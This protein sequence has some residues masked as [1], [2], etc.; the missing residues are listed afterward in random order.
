VASEQSNGLAL[1]VAT[2]LGLQLD[3]EVETVQVPSISGEFGV[4]TGHL[5]LLAAL[6]PGVLRYRKQGQLVLA[7]VGAGFVEAQATRVQ[8]I[9]EFFVMPADVDVEKARQDLVAAEQRLKTLTGTFGDPEH[10]EAQRSYD[11]AVARIAVASG[12]TN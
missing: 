11:W 1:Q 9:T 8:L 10:T 6:K 3:I 4:L 2:P 12:D 7:A 5:P